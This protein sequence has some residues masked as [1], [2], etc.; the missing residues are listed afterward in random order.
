MNSIVVGCIIAALLFGGG[1]YIGR[2]TA[3]LS[4]AENTIAQTQTAAAGTA[5]NIARRNAADAEQQ[6]SMLAF[7]RGV[8]KDEVQSY[9]LLDR[10]AQHFD[11]LREQPTHTEPAATTIAAGSCRAER[12]ETRRL[13]G[14]LRT[15]LERFRGEAERANQYT[16]LLNECIGQLDRDRSLMQ[17]YK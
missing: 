5:H 14:Q 11:R 7:H 15:A 4:V 2:V 12:A 16:R 1:V 8:T 6:Q 17:D 9:V 3:Q 13:S 10:V